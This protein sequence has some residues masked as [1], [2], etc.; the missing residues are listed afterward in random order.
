M[1][2]IRAFALVI[3]L[4]SITTASANNSHK[5]GQRASVSS[6]GSE[7]WR[8]RGGCGRQLIHLARQPPR[9]RPSPSRNSSASPADGGSEL[10]DH[11]AWVVDALWT[12]AGSDSVNP[13]AISVTVIELAPCKKISFSVSARNVAVT[14]YES[15]QSNSITRVRSPALWPS[16]HFP[17]GPS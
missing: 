15:A 10:K 6:G 12:R 11:D 8:V 9:L 13:A 3:P 16:V 4:A 7:R 2:L 17:T 14:G 5:N 1:V